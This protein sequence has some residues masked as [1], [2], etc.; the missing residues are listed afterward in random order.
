MDTTLLAGLVA[1]A[2][3]G[4][5]APCLAAWWSANWERVRMAEKALAADEAAERLP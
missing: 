4:V 1:L 2:A 3:F 5:L